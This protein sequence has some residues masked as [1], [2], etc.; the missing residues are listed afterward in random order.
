M[1]RRTQQPALEENRLNLERFDEANV[2]QLGLISIQERIPTDFHEWEV[3]F[4]IEGRPALLRC[5]GAA[6]LGV[7][8][9]IDGDVASAIIDLYLEAGAPPDGTVRTTSYRLLKQAGFPNAGKYYPMLRESLERLRGSTYYASEAWRDHSRRRWMTVTF[10]YLE[11][12]GYVEDDADPGSFSRGTELQLKLAQPIVNSIRARYVKPLDRAFLNSLERPLTR[13]LYRLLDARRYGPDAPDGE[14]QMEFTVAL[15]V[16]AD[17]CKVTD[18]RPDKI[19]RTLAGAHEELLARGYLR[20]VA[21]M[22]R[23]KKQVIRYVF[24]PSVPIPPEAARTDETPHEPVSPV[25]DASALSPATARLRE[26]GVSL[27]MARRLVAEFGEQHVLERIAKFHAIL[28]SGVQPRRPSALLIDVVRDDGSKYV[29]PEGYTPRPPA[30]K[31]EERPATTD[32][33]RA[34]AEAF[35]ERLR[36]LPRDQQVREILM[37]VRFLLQSYLTQ[38]HLER[39]EALLLAGAQEPL[40][41]HSELSRA[42]AERRVKA[43]AEGLMGWLETAQP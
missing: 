35:H 39:L 26:Q 1:A 23:G 40:E 31:R 36:S 8:H 16:W 27:A 15:L 28:A 13:A 34:A 12:L 30:E 22:G 19:R 32:D 25:V 3:S 2:S 43:Y 37:T 6:G 9:G 38:R 33:E 20:E 17:A 42:I 11:G 21:Y 24:S 41:L 10:N 4:E 14:P 18:K 7:P 29:D 5:R